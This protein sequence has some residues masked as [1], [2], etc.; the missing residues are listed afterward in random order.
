MTLTEIHA[1]SRH[2]GDPAP[3]LLDYR[4]VHR[5]MTVDFAR[6]ATVATELAAHPDPARM[7]ALRRYLEAMSAEVASHHHVEDADVWPILVAV[8]ATLPGAGAA[9]R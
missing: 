9:H 3:D 6:L 7:A 1:A 5:A 4:L 8:G 2:P